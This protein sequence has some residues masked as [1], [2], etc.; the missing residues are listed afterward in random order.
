MS[1]IPRVVDG[2]DRR[3]LRLLEM[4]KYITNKTEQDEGATS[5]EIKRMMLLKFGLKHKTTAEYLQ[6]CDVG[7]L[8]QQRSDNLKWVVTKNYRKYADLLY[9]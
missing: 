6:E 5:N 1:E 7:Q 9:G 8:V 2:A 3:K 4:L